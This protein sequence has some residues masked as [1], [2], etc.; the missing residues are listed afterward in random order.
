VRGIRLDE[1][2]FVKGVALVEED[3]MLITIT[4]KGFGK[5][6]SFDEFAR[7]NRGGK[8]VIC[9]N[10]ND[11]TGLLAGILTVDNKD[12]IMLITNDGT[13]IRTAV[14]EIP[15]YSRTASG[16]IVMR[17]DEESIVANITRVS[18]EDEEEDEKRRAEEA[19]KKEAL[20]S[21]N[22]EALAAF[23]EASEEETESEEE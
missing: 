8:G 22:R 14:S 6:S 11:K 12:D 10:L 21:G 9:H 17:P 19:L 3:K 15:S 4:E 2:D 5:R 13:V 7:R 18:R 16:V 1:G 23:D 20:E